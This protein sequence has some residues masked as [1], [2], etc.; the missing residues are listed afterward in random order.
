M[1]EIELV[2]WINKLIAEDK[3]YKFYKNKLWIDL[4]NEVLKEQH[5]E[6]QDCKINGK[7][8]NGNKQFIVPADTVH[9]EKFVKDFPQYALS[10]C[11]IINGIKTRQ[12][13]CLCNEC[14]NKRHERFGYITQKEILNEEKW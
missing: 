1:T 5:Y 9:H 7:I 11:I 13:T 10:K 14:H 12:L 8:I 2:K 6:C 3:M 4:K